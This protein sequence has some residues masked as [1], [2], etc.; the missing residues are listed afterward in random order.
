MGWRISAGL[1][2]VAGLLWPGALPAQDRHEEWARHFAKGPKAE[3]ECATFFGAE[4]HEE[5]V[6][7]A[8]LP[9]GSVLVCGNSWG[10]SFPAAPQA[11]VLGLDGLW[12]CALHEAGMEVD[13]EGRPR[14]PSSNNPNRTG[15][16]LF[17][18]DDLTKMTR[19]VRFGWGIAS[20]SAA[21]QMS[22]KTFVI[23]GQSTPAFRNL[24]KQAKASFTLPRDMANSHM[25]PYSYNDLE[26]PGDVYVAKLSPD[27]STFLWVW[28]LEAHREVPE[29]IFE[30]RAGAVVFASCGVKSVSADGQNLEPLKTR[31]MGGGSYVHKFLDVNPKDG[32]VLFGGDSQ[33]GTGREPYRK[34]IVVGFT[35]E[36]ETKWR[37][38]D[39][40]GP[41]VGHDNYRLVSDSSARVASFAPNGDLAIAFW[42]D[43]GNTIV[44]RNPVDL[45][46]PVDSQGIGMSPWG[47]KGAKSYAHMVR[48]NPETC[49]RVDYTFWATYTSTEP[50]SITIDGMLALSSRETVVWGGAASWLVQTPNA[51][52]SAPDRPK[53]GRG[54]YFTIFEPGFKNAEFSSSLPQCAIRDAIEGRKGLVL[55]STA[56]GQKD[57]PDAGGNEVPTRKACQATFGGGLSDGHVLLMRLPG[58]GPE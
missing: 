7:G 36:G 39:F 29:R 15:F 47:T 44:N 51:F 20:I 8:S 52:Y 1:V 58:R 33:S 43:G 22:D 17:L 45:D 55:I 13:K 23:A 25:G 18:S 3:L 37:L 57:G 26:L 2:A 16:L 9:D 14:P 10:P 48:F 24:M 46:R 56:R 12:K 5:F 31:K 30:G 11:Q 53:A 41:V 40:D 27:L 50:N 54:T 49:E 6:G 34:P 4:G 38:Y 19:L 35:P 32:T 42:S 21:R 28:V